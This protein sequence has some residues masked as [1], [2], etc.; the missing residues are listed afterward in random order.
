MSIAKVIMFGVEPIK[1]LKELDK[2]YAEHYFK[3]A[4]ADKDDLGDGNFENIDEAIKEDLKELQDFEKAQRLEV[5]DRIKTEIRHNTQLIY[6]I[7]LMMNIAEDYN[8]KQVLWDLKRHLNIEIENLKDSKEAE[9]QLVCK[10][11]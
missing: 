4:E 7:K 9:Q 2:E 1:A 8:A 10:V 5:L 3:E 11:R 6:A